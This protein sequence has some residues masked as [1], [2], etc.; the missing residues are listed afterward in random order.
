MISEKNSSKKET[1]DKCRSGLSGDHAGLLSADPHQ[2]D[3][4]LT[5]ELQEE[6]Y[7]QKGLC[8]GPMKIQA[9]NQAYQ[10]IGPGLPPGQL[11]RLCIRL[12]WM[13]RGSWQKPHTTD[14]LHL[15]GRGYRIPAQALQETL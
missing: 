2:P 6:R 14:G 11:C 7:K 8:A 3:L 1:L 4:V 9:L 5:G 15:S 13:K 12:Y 10:R